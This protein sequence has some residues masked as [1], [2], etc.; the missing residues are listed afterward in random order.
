MYKSILFFFPSSHVNISEDLNVNKTFIVLEAFDLDLNAKLVY[1]LGLD[2]HSI[3]AYDEY[4]RP[5]NSSL[6]KV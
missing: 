5:I 2:N 4:D 1:S 6:V 3:E